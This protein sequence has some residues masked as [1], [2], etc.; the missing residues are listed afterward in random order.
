MSNIPPMKTHRSRVPIDLSPLARFS[1]TVDA[2]TLRDA[3][4]IARISG[5]RFSF[6]R[7]VNDVL[8]REVRAKEQLLI[9]PR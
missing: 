8:A 7:W 4:T 3:Q 1:A 5:Y 6:S 9:G 2:D